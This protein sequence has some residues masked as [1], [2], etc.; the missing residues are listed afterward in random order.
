MKYLKFALLGFCITMVCS[1]F[2]WKKGDKV[3]AFGVASSFKDSVVYVTSVQ[4]LDSVK[5][6]KGGVLPKR[7]LYSYQLK[8][9][10]EAQ[11]K[12]DRVCMI[13]FSH[14]QESLTK[15]TSKLKNRFQKNKQ[16]V[17]LLDSD[18]FSFTKPETE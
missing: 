1:S 13:Y 5:L 2:S 3:Y 7:D 17:E 9:F 11:G 12:Q 18:K 4:V 14:S 10:L 15:K 8:N 16:K 6:L